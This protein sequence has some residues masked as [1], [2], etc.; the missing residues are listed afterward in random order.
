MCPL[1]AGTAGYWFEMGAHT[2][3]N[4]YGSLLTIIDEL[5]LRDRML[6]RKR[7]PYRLLVEGKLRSIPRS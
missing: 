5:G 2:L 6:T 3:Y 7:A 1:P 4:S